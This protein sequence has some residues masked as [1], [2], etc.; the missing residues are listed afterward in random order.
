VAFQQTFVQEFFGAKISSGLIFSGNGIVSSLNK[1]ANENNLDLAILKN[2]VGHT[3]LDVESLDEEMGKLKAW[4]S[5]VCNISFFSSSTKKGEFNDS[6]VNV[7]EKL[8]GMESMNKTF[9]NNLMNLE[10]MN[11]TVEDNILGLKVLNST[12]VNK[13][14]LLIDD[15]NGLNDTLESAVQDNKDLHNVLNDTMDDV[16]V[17]DNRISSLNGTVDN[18]EDKLEGI[19]EMNETLKKNSLDINILKF[20]PYRIDSLDNAIEANNVKISA[21]DDTIADVTSDVNDLDDGLD[22]LNNTVD[23]CR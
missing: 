5:F 23:I 11:Q 7:N 4:Q 17:L 1:T 8:D 21:L 18:V 9:E 3:I 14:E 16:K 22:Q 12:M 2:A 6:I 20:L 13:N 19:G 10:I 15:I